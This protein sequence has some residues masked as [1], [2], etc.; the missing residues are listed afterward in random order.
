VPSDDDESAAA[1]EAAR[2]T[3]EE[4]LIVTNRLHQVHAYASCCVTPSSLLGVRAVCCCAV[5]GITAHS[6]R[7]NPASATVRQVA[8]HLGG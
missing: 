1:A 4:A 6:S 5:Q 2:L 3:D 7:C 8:S